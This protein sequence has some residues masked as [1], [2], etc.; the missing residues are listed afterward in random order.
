[1]FHNGYAYRIAR[2]LG[3][4]PL[5]FFVLRLEGDVS[6]EDFSGHRVSDLAC[7]SAEFARRIA[8]GELSGRDV[9]GVEIAAESE[10]ALLPEVNTLGVV[11]SEPAVNASVQ[12]VHS[13]A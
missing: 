4:P 10:T 7:R 11:D 1:M 6:D 8:A 13:E 2:V 3:K 5:Q 9:N 12:E